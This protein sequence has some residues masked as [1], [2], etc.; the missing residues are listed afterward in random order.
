MLHKQSNFREYSHLLSCFKIAI[1]SE[2][3]CDEM[4]EWE[5]GII[6]RTDGEK[7]LIKAIKSTFLKNL[8]INGLNFRSK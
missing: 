6:F 5:A 1:N 4:G 2:I 3:I 7:A 8:D